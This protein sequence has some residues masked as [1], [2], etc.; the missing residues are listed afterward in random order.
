MLSCRRGFIDLTFLIVIIFVL[1]IAAFVGYIILDQTSTALA[2]SSAQAKAIN[3]SV[4]QMRGALV[5]GLDVGIPFIFIGIGVTILAIS[6]FVRASPFFYLIGFLFIIISVV[7]GMFFSNIYESL[8]GATALSGVSAQF[9][10]TG[11]LFANLPIFI[12]VFALLMVIIFL[13]KR[14]GGGDAYGL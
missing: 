11:F 3:S 2:G 10:Y 12:G 9:S 6:Y 14:S 7:M 8:A 13:A 5:S 4:V 1:T